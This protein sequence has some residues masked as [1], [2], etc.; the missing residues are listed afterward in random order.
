MLA[1]ARRSRR[2]RPAPA[3]AR[4]RRVEDHR[5]AG[6]GAE[7]REVPHVHDEVAVAEEGAALGHRDVAR[8]RRS[9]PSRPRPA[10][11]SGGI[12]CPFLTFTGLPVRPAATSRSVC[13][14]RKAGICST[15]TTSAAARGLRRPR[16]CRSGPEGR[17]PRAPARAR[18]RPSSSPGPR[19]AAAPGAVGL[20]E[21]GLEADRDARAG[22]D[23]RPA[24]RRRAAAR[25]PARPR[26][27]R[28]S[29]TAPRAKRQLISARSRPAPSARPAP[30]LAAAGA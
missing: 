25:R 29:G 26:R 16:G 30:T 17:S 20:V 1:L 4:V 28:R 12:H 24:P 15:S 5:R 10:I 6:G 27:G 8:C 19:G 13:R 9:A 21:A 7:P 11:P 2:P 23:R 22:A 3:A 14:Q 18:A